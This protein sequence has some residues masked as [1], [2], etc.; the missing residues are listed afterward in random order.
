MLKEASGCLKDVSGCY[1]QASGCVHLSD[2]ETTNRDVAETKNF[3]IIL[4]HSKD[5]GKNKSP[6]IRINIMNEKMDQNLKNQGF[7]SI[8][9]SDLGHCRVYIYIHTHSKI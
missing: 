6:L 3:N 1:E 2:P 9:K 4:H 7:K 8:E 5:L